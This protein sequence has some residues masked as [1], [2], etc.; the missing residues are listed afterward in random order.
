MKFRAGLNDDVWADRAER[1][2]VNTRP[3]IGTAR[4]DRG[5]V[6]AGAVG[7]VQADIHYRIHGV[8]FQTSRLAK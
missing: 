2:D 4:D 8:P 5:R 7:H 6:D 1:T 3:D